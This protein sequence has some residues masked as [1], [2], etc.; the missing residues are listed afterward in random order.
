M[1]KIIR[2]SYVYFN[3]IIFLNY[4]IGRNEINMPIAGGARFAG[5][6]S[7]TDISIHDI[8]Q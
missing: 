7:S 3:I 5:M 6:I 8:S 4:I 1:N 2:L